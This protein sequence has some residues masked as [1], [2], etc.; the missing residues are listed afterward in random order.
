MPNSEI[1]SQF[2]FS[3][4]S[5]NLDVGCFDLGVSFSDESPGKSVEHDS[6]AEPAA[7]A[8]GRLVAPVK[9]PD[10]HHRLTE[11]TWT[12]E[13]QTKASFDLWTRRNQNQQILIPYWLATCQNQSG[14]RI[15]WFWF[16]PVHKSN[17]A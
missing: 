1:V 9:S 16:L 6:A 15:F 2:R 10:K 7:A 17:A 4:C 3:L 12:P 11:N 14:D 13:V 5:V 8:A